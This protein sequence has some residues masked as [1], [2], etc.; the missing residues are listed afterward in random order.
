MHRD[1]KPENVLLTAATPE[2]PHGRVKVAD[3]GLA[4]SMAD[5]TCAKVSASAFEVSEDSGIEKVFA[6]IVDN[7]RHPSLPGPRSRL[8]RQPALRFQG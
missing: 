4:K 6:L 8:E 3:F 2:H 1:L 7:V 5:G